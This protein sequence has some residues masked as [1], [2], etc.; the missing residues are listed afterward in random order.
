MSPKKKTRPKSETGR[1]FEA[2]FA[3]LEQVVA[4]LER[5][6][7]E[8]GQSLKRYE[9]GIRCLSQCYEFLDAAERRIEL[10]S[11][12]D[13]EGRPV[14]R[15]FGESEMSLEEKQASR[16]RRRSQQKTTPRQPEASERP[17]GLPVSQDEGVS[18]SEEDETG[19]L[20]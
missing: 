6:D 10:V 18:D 20:F 13:P 12:V 14:T 17:S 9:E 4:E 3:A 7:L 16:S 11:Q 1:T 15:P 2:A 8:L 19:Y 5:G